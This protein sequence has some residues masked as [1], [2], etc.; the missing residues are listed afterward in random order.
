MA[1][2]T[3][4]KIEDIKA[5]DWVMSYNLITGVYEPAITQ[6]GA[7]L[8]AQRDTLVDIYLSDNQK[9]S[10]TAGHPILTKGG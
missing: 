4:K 9:I 3:Y 8:F 5:G 7:V 1:D 6:K 10:M 2:Y